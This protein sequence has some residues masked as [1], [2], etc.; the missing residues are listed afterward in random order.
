MKLLPPLLLL[1][2]INNFHATYIS[3]FI[4]WIKTLK[5]LNWL[6]L[7][8]IRLLRKDP[9]ARY[10]HYFPKSVGDHD[11]DDEDIILQLNFFPYFPAISIKT[12]WLPNIQMFLYFVYNMICT[13]IYDVH[14]I[15]FSSATISITKYF[16]NFRFH[17]VD[18]KNLFSMLS[19]LF[20]LLVVFCMIT[21]NT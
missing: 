2:I 12:D 4:V 8:K 19:A 7:R 1:Y 14:K 6:L 13:Y 21:W 15:V 16:V 17:G 9:N 11:D 3:F 10:F 5:L 20:P 18:T